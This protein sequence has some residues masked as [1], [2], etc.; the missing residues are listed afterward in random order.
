MYNIQLMLNSNGEAIPFEINTRI[1]TT[2]CLV[3]QALYKDPFD[4]IISEQDNSESY[5]NYDDD[6][7]LERHWHNYIYT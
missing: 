2:F 3:L 6:V 5:T 7:R 4:M 1:S